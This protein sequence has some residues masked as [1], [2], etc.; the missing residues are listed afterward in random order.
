[1]M[2][3]TAADQQNYTGTTGPLYFL[4]GQEHSPMILIASSTGN[5]AKTFKMYQA[6]AIYT[7]DR[8]GKFTWIC[9]KC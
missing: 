2:A 4:H 8:S 6:F 9:V 3:I 5:A 1:M 7:D